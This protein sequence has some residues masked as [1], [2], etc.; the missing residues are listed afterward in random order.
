MFWVPHEC[1]GRDFYVTDSDLMVGLTGLYVAVLR[2]VEESVNIFSSSVN[3]AAPSSLDILDFQ[4][5]VL[6]VIFGVVC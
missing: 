6:G 1:R 5:H 3:V 2:V 4:V